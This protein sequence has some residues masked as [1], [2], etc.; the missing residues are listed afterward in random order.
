MDIKKLAVGGIVGGILF[1]FLGW[2]LYGMLLMDFMNSHPGVV[3]GYS[4]EAPDMLYLAIGNL[5]SGFMM[6][7]IFIKANINTLMGGLI[8]A[9]VVGLLMAASYDCIMYA[10][11]SLVSKKMML[12]DV[13]ASTAMSA[14]AGAVVGMLMGKLK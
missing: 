10:T 11:T 12:A 13:L 4:K 9:A 6:A 2:L 3:S 7:Y 14:V 5:L 1:F 8:M